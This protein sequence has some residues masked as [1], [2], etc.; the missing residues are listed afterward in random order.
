MATANG[1][2]LW[3]EEGVV[4]AGK[5]LQDLMKVEEFRDLSPAEKR[6][7]TVS[8][9]YCYLYTKLKELDLLVDSEDNYF[10]DETIH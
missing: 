5:M 8:A 1:T 3:L 7:K 4:H 6:I 9:T 10:P 2:K